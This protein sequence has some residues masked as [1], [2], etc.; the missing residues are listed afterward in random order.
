MYINHLSKKIS[1]ILKFMTSQPKKKAIAIHILPN[2][3][4]STGNQTMV[5]GQLAEYKMRN[6]FLEKP[7]TKC[8]G[9]TLF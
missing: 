4:R 9:E 8:G 6:I 1:L 5:F 7:F 2:I 3:S